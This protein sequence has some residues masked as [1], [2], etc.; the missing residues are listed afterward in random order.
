RQ[1]LSE[2]ERPKK[3]R[4]VVV[5]CGAPH[6]GRRKA[7][8]GSPRALPAIACGAESNSDAGRARQGEPGRCLYPARVSRL[9]A[10]TLLA[11]F[12]IGVFLAGLELMITATA[13]PSILLD[14]AV[15]DQL[16]KPA[17]SELRHASWIVNGYLLAYV[18]AM[19]LAGR[20]ADVWGT[21]RL[22]LVALVVFI[23]GSLAAGRAQT[24][25]ELIAGRVI[26]GIGGGILVPVGT[27]AASHLFEGHDRPRALGIIGALTFLGMAAG[28]FLGAA[29][30]GGLDVGGGLER[31]G[32]APG[33][34]LHDALA[35]AWR[36]VFYINVPIGFVAFFVAWAASH[37]WETPRRRAGIDV[38]GAIVWSIALA[39]VLGAT[40][41]IGVTDLGG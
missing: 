30:L 5:C 11:V 24:I 29:L 14:L 9:G 19:P 32:V 33:T 36:W 20:L 34:A 35:P 12:G 40:T 28:P 16:G 13:L 15:T 22:F 18:V 41:L 2:P 38:P 27:A 21:R 8:I 17:F 6:I 26:Q 31:L 4:S 37:G 23:T 1:R 25:D 10:W 7:R 39:A 3:A